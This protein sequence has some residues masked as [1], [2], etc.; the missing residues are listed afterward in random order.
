MTPATSRRKM[1]ISLLEL[2]QLI[3]LNMAMLCFGFSP[4]VPMQSLQ[5]KIKNFATVSGE[6]QLVQEVEEALTAYLTKS[7]ML[8]KV[9]AEAKCEGTAQYTGLLFE[10]KPY[11]VETPHGCPSELETYLE[12]SRY[13]IVNIPPVVMFKAKCFKPSKLCAIYKLEH[14]RNVDYITQSTTAG[15]VGSFDFDL[16]TDDEFRDQII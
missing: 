10:P 9:A 11:S 2:V 15:P 8:R 7:K 1:R 16:G 4:C 13:I 12:D 3:Q 6:V 5:H 14:T